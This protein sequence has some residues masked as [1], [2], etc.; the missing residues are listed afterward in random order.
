MI[1]FVAR[2]EAPATTRI[3]HKVWG[4]CVALQIG[5]PSGPICFCNGK[6]ALD[7]RVLPSALGWM[8]ALSQRE[9]ICDEAATPY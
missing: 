2:P 9:G 3:A 4:Q 8:L 7:F 6:I 1:Y 5:V